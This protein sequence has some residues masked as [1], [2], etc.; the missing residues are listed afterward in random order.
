MSR[1][2]ERR[3]SALA[4]VAI[5][6]LG[7]PVAGGAAL[8]GELAKVG[9]RRWDAKANSDE[10]ERRRAVEEAI[11][12]WAQAE[13]FDV[14]DV[15]LGLELAGEIIVEHGPNVT[16]IADLNFDAD[17]VAGE[18][19]DE[20]RR[21]ARLK[22]P[23]WGSEPHYAVA[24]GTIRATYGSLVGQ[25]RQDAPVLMSLAGKLTEALS[26]L[27][28]IRVA[29][30]ERAS[31]SE[32]MTY[33]RTRLSDW[34]RAI[35]N[36]GGRAPSAVE[37]Q[38]RVEQHSGPEPV[39]TL[40]E[41]E[42][43]AEGRS[44]IVLG[45]PGS[46]KTWLARRYARRAAEQALD[47]LRAGAQ[48]ADVWL[49]VLT[50]WDRWAKT[51][52]SA[53]EALIDASFAA[54]LGHGDIGPDVVTRVRRTLIEHVRVLAV[55][56]SLDEARDDHGQ[57]RLTGLLSTR[58]RIA[59]TSRPDA[60]SIMAV[61][62]HGPQSLPVGHLQDL[63]YPQ[64]V[65]N[66]IRAWFTDDPETGDSLTAQ[67]QE[68]D[69]LKQNAVVP[70]LLT[71]YCLLA[72]EP[73]AGGQLPARRRDLY[74]KLVRRLLLGRW[75][76]TPSRRPDLE[77]CEAE[78]A[79]YAWHAVKGT[80]TSTGLGAWSDTFT[81]PR[82][83]LSGAEARAVDH[84]A[85]AVATD[86]EGQG[87]CRFLHR[88]LLEHFVVE[89]IARLPTAEA[90]EVLLPHLWFDPDWA[91]AAPA[92][93]IAHNHHH[94][95]GGALLREL[96]TRSLA[97]GGDP[98]K[99]EA[100]RQIDQLLLD[101]A[102]DSDPGDWSTELQDLINGLRVRYAFEQGDMTST[103]HWQ[104]STAAVR[105]ALLA[106]S[107]T[108]PI[109]GTLAGRV[110]KLVSVIET[111]TEQVQTRRA[112]IEA[113]PGEDPSDV[114]DLVQRLV[115]RGP[116]EEE[117]AQARRAVVDALSEAADRWVVRDLVRA[118]VSLTVT[119]TERTQTH[120]ALIEA[121]P[122]ADLSDVA[123]LVRAL[124]SLTVTEAER[125]QSRNEILTVLS[126][127]LEQSSLREVVAALRQ[128][129]SFTSWMSWLN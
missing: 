36:L 17:A 103:A 9:A 104:Q 29:V 59:V 19:W 27:D 35:L 3:V 49:P 111:E 81:P 20:A 126:A 85:P 110:G 50:T 125:A 39:P 115:S 121:L 8:A 55:V 113:L 117:R 128:V 122:E 58:W 47:Q 94:G 26:D 72:G 77:A 69:D 74:S 6:S 24:K 7:G 38:L 46:G 61:A 57:Q 106:A 63:T 30:T 124:V 51:D 43:L 64:D 107:L 86:D 93:V 42:A 123:D 129:S 28:D 53:R 78:L 2:T 33:L 79:R 40:S 101:I 56:D 1:D 109:K 84:I 98:A 73:Q 66:F 14:N 82:P 80:V 44:L 90:A 15:A 91:V 32:V 102:R 112:L 71:F 34:D 83:A 60:W 4:A 100:N 13:R 105:S 118:L 88:T 23:L 16:R 99:N 120:R 116:S 68:R 5:A 37:R 87:T 119:E 95:D 70:L 97:T 108:D 31:P 45:G 12:S 22:D 127:E 41:A 52:G 10:R 25:L 75:A 65:E 54:E 21:K 11:Q 114:A 48:V 18:V 96:L 67:I 62:A 92:A 89:H 76:N